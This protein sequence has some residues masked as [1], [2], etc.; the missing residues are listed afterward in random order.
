MNLAILVIL[1]AIIMVPAFF[2]TRKLMN[3]KYLHKFRREWEILN[4]FIIVFFVGYLIIT[5]FAFQGNVKIIHSLTGIIYFMGSLFVFITV[6]TGYK[7][8]QQLHHTTVSKDY[9]D[10][11][12]ESMADTLIV[13]KVGPDL[14]ITKVNRAL[15][16]LLNYTRAEVIGMPL[17]DVLHSNKTVN[18]FINECNSNEWITNE[19]AVYYTKVGEKIPVLISISCIRDSNN[20]MMEMIIAGKDITELKKARRA[21]QTSESK[22]KNLSKRLHESNI[23]KELLLDVITHDLKNPASLIKGF[24]EIGLE[25]HPNDEILKEISQGTESLFKIIDSA[26]IMSKIAT[27]DKIKM[28]ETNIS[29]VVND[30]VHEFTPSATSAG[31][32]LTNNVQEEILLKV[33]PIITEVFRN[34]ISNAIKYAQSGKKIIIDA[35]VTEDNVLFSVTDSGKTILKKYR[36]VIFKRSKQLDSTAGEGLGLA[37]VDRIAKA[38]KANVGVKPNPDG[39][40][41]FYFEMPN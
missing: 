24:S 37:I 1:G 3:S 40:N 15:L 29:K 12:I 38:H 11:I 28:V 26:N 36:N 33:N 10:Q 9:V 14:K 32:K 25:N 35:E 22:Y 2:I 31:I 41:I 16:N 23:M 5:F 20:K 7:T 30:I 13:L 19:E 39:G 27:G 6:R 21:L 34:Y 8:I 4:F 17:K 18:Q